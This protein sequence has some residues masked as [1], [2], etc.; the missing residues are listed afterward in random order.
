MQIT[1]ARPGIEPRLTDH[2]S[3][4]LT[5]YS[6]LPSLPLRFDPLN[7]GRNDTPRIHPKFRLPKPE[8][9]DFEFSIGFLGCARLPYTP[10]R[11]GSFDC[12]PK[13]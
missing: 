13:P 8:K 10:S 9:V 3:A 5:N 11:N 1:W 2:E 12:I 6:I 7:K 4:E